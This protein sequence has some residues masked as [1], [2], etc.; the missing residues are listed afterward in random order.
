MY[1]HP[2]RA[3]RRVPTTP[4]DGCRRRRGPCINTTRWRARASPWLEPIPTARDRAPGNAG[5]EKSGTDNGEDDADDAKDV[6]AQQIAEHQAY[7]SDDQHCPTPLR[8]DCQQDAQGTTNRTNSGRAEG[9]RLRQA[10][11]AYGS[12][13]RSPRRPRL[14]QHKHDVGHRQR[15]DEHA[16]HHER[17]S[18]VSPCA[19]ARGRP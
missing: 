12:T 15:E 5:H 2:R 16:D 3:S 9:A 8:A 18:G 1:A 7:N 19:R 6:N 13:D 17:T 11:P 4:R 14:A 10:Q